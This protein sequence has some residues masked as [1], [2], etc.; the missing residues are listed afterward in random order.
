M[1]ILDYPSLAGPA[2][3]VAE[4][5]RVPNLEE[6]VSMRDARVDGV[7]LLAESMP[8]GSEDASLDWLS[9]LSGVRLL[10]IG[11]NPLPAIPPSAL[12]TLDT[13]EVTA[14]RATVK[15]DLTHLSNVGVIAGPTRIFEGDLRACK[16]L[17]V[18]ALRGYSEEDLKPLDGCRAL[19]SARLRGV[20]GGLRLGWTDPPSQLRE[21]YLERFRLA[22]LEGVDQLSSLEILSISVARS[23]RLPSTTLD[24]TPLLRCANLKVLV[25]AGAAS[26]LGVDHVRALPKIATVRVQTGG[27]V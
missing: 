26:V 1:I 25:I 5:T 4:L 8:A 11:W 20:G 17:E 13:L 22:G 16:R 7:V 15:V 21:L 23:S 19:R 10:H 27:L 3:R 2:Y 24:L 12:A 14:N 6:I 18:V 9:F